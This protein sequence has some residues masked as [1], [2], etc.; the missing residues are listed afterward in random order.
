MPSRFKHRIQ[1]DS[2]E[3]YHLRWMIPWLM[4][5]IDITYGE[6]LTKGRQL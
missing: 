3:F 4:N 5:T 6:F 2:Q 1:D